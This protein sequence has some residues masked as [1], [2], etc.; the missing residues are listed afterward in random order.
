MHITHQWSKL[1]YIYIL[2]KI[3]H[4][5]KAR[6]GMGGVFSVLESDLNKAPFLWLAIKEDFIQRMGNLLKCRRAKE[7]VQIHRWVT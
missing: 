4:I 2:H 5:H 6:W 3:I 7:G 1:I